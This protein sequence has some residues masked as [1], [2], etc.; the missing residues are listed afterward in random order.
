MKW[1]Y[2]PLFIILICLA[3]F[4]F[5]HQLIFNTRHML[6]YMIIVG[7]IIGI[8]YLLYRNFMKKNYGVSYQKKI[9]SSHR[10]TTTNIVP[11]RNVQKMKRTRQKPITKRSSAPN[12]TVIEGKKGKKKNRALF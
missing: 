3:I 5:I 11:H 9:K 12:L 1:K 8:L 10:P 4:G 7:A 6:T 2:H